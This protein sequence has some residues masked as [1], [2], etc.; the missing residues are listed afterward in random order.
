MTPPVPDR[1]IRQRPRLFWA[2]AFP[3]LTQHIMATTP[4]VTLLAG[5]ASGT[6]M[7]AL[8][9]HFAGHTPLNQ[10]AVRVTFL[11]VVAALA[12][13]PHL[14]LRP[15]IET[16]PVPAWIASAGQMLLALPVLALTCWV[17]LRLMTTTVPAG[18]AGH[19]PAFYPLL[20]QLMGWSA[21]EVA[22]ANCC[23]RTRYAALSGAIA[24]SVTFVAIAAATFI[25]TLKRHL[26]TPPATPHAATIAWYT[27]TAV[28]L[29]L[30]CVAI[31]DQW[32]RYTRRLHL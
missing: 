5:C 8:M 20:A 27:I 29:A 23:E 30:T 28:M 11:P 4:W 12:F 3:V 21:L 19:L 25:P 18:S 15:I 10:N 32:Q 24:A 14:H 17:Q 16:T 26:L 6:V 1:A 2:R 7:L 13:V 31:R 9:A 22:L